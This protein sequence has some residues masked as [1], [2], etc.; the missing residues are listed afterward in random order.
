MHFIFQA[1]AEPMSNSFYTNWNLFPCFICYFLQVQTMLLCKHNAKTTTKHMCS[2]S[3]IF[4]TIYQCPKY[5]K[6]TLSDKDTESATTH[7]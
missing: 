6:F 2:H 1:R 7:S 5:H 4:K 3:L